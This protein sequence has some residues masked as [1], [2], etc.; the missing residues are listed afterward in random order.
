MRLAAPVRFFPANP[1]ELNLSRV[2]DLLGPVGRSLT[3]FRSLLQKAI[4]MWKTQ[5][6]DRGGLRFHVWKKH[7]QCSFRS[8]LG[9]KLNL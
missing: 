9:G 6:R 1:S 8:I 5:H 4:H 3:R 2:C 7:I